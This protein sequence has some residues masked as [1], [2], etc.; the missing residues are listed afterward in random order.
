MDGLTDDVEKSNET[1]IIST[2]I[3]F[4]HFE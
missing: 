1:V 3:S 2:T 4:Y